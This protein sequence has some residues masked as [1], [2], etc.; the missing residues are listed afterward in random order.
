MILLKIIL[1]IITIALLI[2]SIKDAYVYRNDKDI[3]VVL[4]VIL[5]LVYIIFN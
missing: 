2:V 1:L 3:I 5:Y 4:V